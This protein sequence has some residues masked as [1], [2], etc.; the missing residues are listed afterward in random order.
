MKILGLIPARGGSKGIPGKNIKALGGK[1]LL[2]YTFD[3][4]Q[5]SKL[6]SKVILSSDDSDIIAVANQIG[7]EV[8]FTRPE[9][10][11]ND[12]SP[13]LPVIAHA[14]RF[15]EEKGEKFDAVCLLQTTYPFRRKGLIDD[16]IKEFIRTDA[17]AL[18]SVLPVP[19]EFN[20]HW[21][22]EPGQNGFLE[23]ATGEKQIIPRRQDLPT[24]FFRDGAIYITKSEVILSKNSIL[25]E[26]LA[27]IVGDESRY[28]NLDTFDDWKKAEILVN[29][30]FG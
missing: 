11:A 1:P 23:I 17:E 14:L 12:Q 20:P 9:N 4:A 28:V 13:T 19:H 27:Y 26:K 3:S 8:P 22:F 2:A 25:S 18:V 15:F 5:E 24:S 7:L 29:K 10:L 16:A 30:L 6:L 21:V